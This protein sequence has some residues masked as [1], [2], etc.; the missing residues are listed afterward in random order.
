MTP[1]SFS[2]Y[3]SKAQFARRRLTHIGSSDIPIICGLTRKWQ[4]N[5]GIATP[6]DLWRFKTKTIEAPQPTLAMH[7]G[8]KLE[9]IVGAEYLSHCGDEDISVWRGTFCEYENN[10]NF[11]ASADMVLQQRGRDGFGASWD[12]GKPWL[13]E[14]K[15]TSGRGIRPLHGTGGYDVKRD[16]ADGLPIATYLQVQWQLLCYDLPKADVALLWYTNHF[17]IFENITPNIKVQEKCLAIAENFLRCVRRKA[18][19]PPV[20]VKD[21]ESIFTAVNDAAAVY[22]LGFVIENRE[23][24]RTVGDIFARYHVLAEKEKKIKEE[25]EDLRAAVALL[26]GNNKEIMTPEGDRLA[27]RSVSQ[28]LKFGNELK[29]RM[30]AMMVADGELEVSL[31][32][33]APESDVGRKLIAAGVA[34]VKKTQT[35]RFLNYFREEKENEKKSKS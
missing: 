2:R 16:D 6:L 26:I 31:S 24:E 33:I 4:K 3:R 30:L 1:S 8:K 28:R 22:D 17:N 12:E 23:K 7:L 11:A 15:T 9:V 29:L 10:R 20:T 21:V 13:V 25:K 35:I 5:G 18:T 32:G 14:C 34:D 19:P 27:T